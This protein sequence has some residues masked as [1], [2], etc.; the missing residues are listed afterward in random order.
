MRTLPPP[1]TGALGQLDA[2]PEITLELADIQPHYRTLEGVVC[3]GPTGAVIA[4]DG[5][6]VMACIPP[7]DAQ[8]P[9]GRLQV[10][11]I[12][13][14]ASAGG[15]GPFLDIA[16]VAEPAAG[17]CL[18]VCGPV[19]RVLWR[20][21]LG[22]G[23]L[24][25]DSL[26]SGRTWSAPAQ[27]FDP[28]RAVY[29]I[30]CPGDL[31]VVILLCA[32]TLAGS[33][34]IACWRLVSGVWSG[35]DWPVGDV[36]GL[37]G[38]TA[39]PLPTG[40]GCQVLYTAQTA[41][42][43]GSYGLLGVSIGYGTSVSWTPPSFLLPLDAQAGLYLAHPRVARLGDRY[44][45]TY[46]LGDSGAASGSTWSRVARC[47]SLDLLHWSAPLEDS[48][49]QEYGA[50]WLAHAGGEFLV[51]AA[52]R[53]APPFDRSTGYRDL[54]PDLMRL[55]LIE[56]EGSPARLTATLDNSDG[57]Y[58]VLPALIPNAQLLLSQGVAG[59]G[60]LGT[61]LLYLEGWIHV[62]T[63][64]TCQLVLTAGDRAGSLARQAKRPIGYTAQSVGFIAR[65]LAALAGF[66]EATIVDSAAQMSQLVT[67]FTI[68]QGET[69]LRALARLLAVYDGSFRVECRSGTGVAFAY[70]ERLRIAAKPTN[71]AAL[72]SYGDDVA[73][74]QI[75]RSGA[76]AN[77]ILVS[78]PQSIPT[79]VADLWDWADLEQTGDEHLAI[80]VEPLLTDRLG[81]GLRAT[82]EL[83]REQRLA[84]A[85]QAA[86]TPHPA[87]EVLDVVTFQ[88]AR[89]G[90][91][92]C[93][94]S[95]LRLIW[96]PGGP[97]AALVLEATGV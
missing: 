7:D 46:V 22:T 77:H 97:E 5:A 75:H 69:Y 60:R 37:T 49:A 72:W 71:E 39:A 73:A 9:Y 3:Q 67:T 48:A 63:H 42:T 91:V 31:G 36:L 20:S 88:D 79:A 81:A 96:R 47:E 40:S 82:L 86:T 89:V 45:L 55:E 52:V 2:V 95:G 65:D 8:H 15:W 68:Q 19:V 50:D 53:Y 32:S 4:P 34:R 62:R 29:G 23:I 59:A 26:D 14:P 11:R 66:R 13:T 24:C 94:L 80:A 44:R 27:L 90:G 93:R 61:H 51:G 12:E 84:L 16:T 54:T 33:F 57:T 21:R 17:V 64:D 28:G 78:G 56:R 38:L 70:V 41:P 58:T 74:L 85:V 43:G 92:N 6:V 25:A 76:R 30:G 10:R 35:T 1:L 18:A 83:A 87:L